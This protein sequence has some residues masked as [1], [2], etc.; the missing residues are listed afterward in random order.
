MMIGL[1]C[2]SS[3]SLTIVDFELFFVNRDNTGFKRRNS[4][5]VS[6]IS[7][8]GSSN[9]AENRSSFRG[10]ARNRFVPIKSLRPSSSNSCSVTNL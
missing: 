2:P 1:V 7:K 9:N 3:S 4:S 6:S 5:L 10:L 8:F